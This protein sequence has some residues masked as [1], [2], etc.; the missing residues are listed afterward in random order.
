M[1]GPEDATQ[2]RFFSKV[3]KTESCW[4]W[5]GAQNGKG[6]GRFGVNRKVVS[7]HRYSYETFN[8]PITD[9]MIVCHT[10]DVRHCVN[11]EHL[12]LGTVAD[13]NK[14]MFDKGRNGASKIGRAHV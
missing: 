12:W 4:L 9:G 11:P 3:N 10:C 1:Q 8:G 13:N 14:D 7:A 6:Y 5:V 2:K